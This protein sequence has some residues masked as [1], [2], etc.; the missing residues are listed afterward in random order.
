MGL[1]N[2]RDDGA[3]VPSVLVLHQYLV[4]DSVPAVADRIAKGLPELPM[5]RDPEES[6]Y[7]RQ[8]AMR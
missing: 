6:W 3:N 5:I 4:T 7:V 2:R 8:N 1:G